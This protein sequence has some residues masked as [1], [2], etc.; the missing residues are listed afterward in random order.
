MHAEMKVFGEAAPNHVHDASAFH[1]DEMA[2]FLKECMEDKHSELA[3]E[4]KVAIVSFQNTPVGMGPYLVLAG[5]PQTINES[6]T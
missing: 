4:T 3:A 1:N 2:S 6:N 5:N